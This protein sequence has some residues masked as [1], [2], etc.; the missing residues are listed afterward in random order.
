MQVGR[1]FRDAINR[2]QVFWELDEAP[3]LSITRGDYLAE[4]AAQP[5]SAVAQ[6]EP[7]VYV[8]GLWVCN[9]KIRGAVMSFCKIDV[10]GRDRNDVDLGELQA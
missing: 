6:P 2:S 4:A 5:T 3:L 8:R 9:T 10:S 7:G 1:A